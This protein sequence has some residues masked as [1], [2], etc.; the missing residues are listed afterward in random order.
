MGTPAIDES[1][2]PSSIKDLIHRTKRL[3]KEYRRRT[4]RPLGV[5]AE[6]GEYE[7]ARL[8]GLRLA[9]VRQPGYDAVQT[10]GKRVRRLQIK[11]RSVL[12]GS[13]P[14]Q[15]LGSIRF[16]HE[17]D[18]VLLVLLDGDLEPMIIYE[19][20]RAALEC[21]LSA[22]GSRARNE[23]GQLGVAAFRT[24]AKVVWECPAGKTTTPRSTQRRRA[25]GSA[26]STH[27]ASGGHAPG[28][29]PRGSRTA[30]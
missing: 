14:G 5:T 20:P 3:A 10:V 19:A 29:P 27:A 7:A 8:L 23:R 12:E 16:K 26:E 9:P 25:P 28:P 11:A 15:R 18:A 4:G 21:A 30:S 13:K 6:I 1:F 22:P 24:I 2:D 17:W